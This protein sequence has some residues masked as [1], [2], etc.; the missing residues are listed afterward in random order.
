MNDRVVLIK[1]VKIAPAA[2]IAA[3]T[4]CFAP[5]PFVDQVLSVLLAFTT[6]NWQ[7]VL[8]VTLAVAP[9]SDLLAFSNWQRVL[10]V[11]LAVVILARLAQFSALR[12]A[13]LG[14]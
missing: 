10:R 6:I 8:R 12:S 2:H 1:R 7:R 13:T 5:R 4:V 3:D 14:S 9:L 11:T